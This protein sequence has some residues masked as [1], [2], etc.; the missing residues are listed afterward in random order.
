MVHQMMPR[1]PVCRRCYIGGVKY[2]FKSMPQFMRA[3]FNQNTYK[4]PS[5]TCQVSGT[6]TGIR[7]HLKRCRLL[8]V[9]CRLKGCKEKGSCDF[10]YG[11]HL[12]KCEFNLTTCLAC[13][14]TMRRNQQA[15]HKCVPNIIQLSDVAKSSVAISRKLSSSN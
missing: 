4:C 13:E 3:L 8:V 9:E 1:C 5:E 12:E 15:G 6:L 14:A 7:K 2:T 10:I 11:E